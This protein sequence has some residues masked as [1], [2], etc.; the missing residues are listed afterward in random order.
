MCRPKLI[1]WDTMLWPS[2]SMQANGSQPRFERSSVAVSSPLRSNEQ[3]NYCRKQRPGIWNNT[4]HPLQVIMVCFLDKALEEMHRWLLSAPR[5]PEAQHVQVQLHAHTAILA[6]LG[7]QSSHCM[8]C[9]RVKRIPDWDE[10]VLCN[11]KLIDWL[12]IRGTTWDNIRSL[13]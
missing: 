5:F 4:V 10:K 1:G 8:K 9:F 13:T 2:I 7:A 3:Q 11:W 12:A 6:F